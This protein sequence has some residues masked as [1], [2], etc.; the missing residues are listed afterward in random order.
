MSRIDVGSRRYARSG[1]PESYI[2]NAVTRV[3][4]YYGRNRPLDEQSKGIE[5]VAQAVS[6]MDSVTQQNLAGRGIRSSSGGAGR[7]G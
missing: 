2:V 6:E 7:S 3:T 1:E 4:G 5:Q